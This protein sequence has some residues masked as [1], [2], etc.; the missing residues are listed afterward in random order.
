MSANNYDY[1]YKILLLGESGVG[2]TTLLGR[3]LDNSFRDHLSSMGPDFKI[4]RIEL[5]IGKLVKL[6]IWD[7][8]GAE[9]RRTL[10]KTY[11]KVA[12]GII[13]LYDVTDLNCF[14]YVNNWI[15]S[16]KANAQSNV[17][18]YLVG[19]KIDRKEERKVAKEE[20]EILAEKNG[21]L[22]AEISSKT[23]YNV[24]EIFQ[25]LTETIYRHDT[26][27]YDV[28]ES[29]RKKLMKFINY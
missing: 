2:K 16:I 23:G 18:V 11:I 8:A 27:F 1:L 3:Y 17:V 25:D 5:S 6:Q 22:F 26:Y 10:T 15:N 4:K 7:T 21:F 12:H 29:A 9:S 24:N 20:G 14:K 13:L 28:G 19:T